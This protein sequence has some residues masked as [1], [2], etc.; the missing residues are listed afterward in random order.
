MFAIKT[1]N[2]SYSEIDN[3][4]LETLLDLICVYDKINDNT[5]NAAKSKKGTV[6]YKVIDR[7]ENT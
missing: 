3:M 5:D 6:T 2:S 7:K 4:E 1:F